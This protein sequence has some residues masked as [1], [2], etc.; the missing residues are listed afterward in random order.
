MAEA[1][2]VAG[3]PH[4]PYGPIALA[5]TMQVD[6]CSPNV[7]IQEQSFGIHYNQ[8]YDLL[9]FVNNKEIFHFQDGFVGIPE[10]P[11]LGI[12]IDEDKVKQVAKEGLNW[13]NPSW[14]NYDG[15][16]AEW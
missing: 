7:F 9:D 14:K 15:A 5:A 16:V 13:R 4:A 1:F 10:G 11:G 8:G 2:D 6:A 3:A 12:D